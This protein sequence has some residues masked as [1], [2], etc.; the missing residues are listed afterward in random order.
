MAKVVKAEQVRCIKPAGR[1]SRIE[2]G[3][4]HYVVV[5]LR[6]E[7]VEKLLTEEHPQGS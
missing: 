6:L 7:M 1:Y 4:D 3:L 5:P 2:F